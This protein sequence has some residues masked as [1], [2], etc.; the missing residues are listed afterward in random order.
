MT[1]NADDVH[2]AQLL[3]V[4]AAKHIKNPPHRT[5]SLYVPIGNMCQLDHIS[6][7]KIIGTDK[8]D[9]RMV[10]GIGPMLD[11]SKVFGYTSSSVNII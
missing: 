8:I 4:E 3:L 5:V 11:W 10:K 6:E 9:F 2:I 1:M 7:A